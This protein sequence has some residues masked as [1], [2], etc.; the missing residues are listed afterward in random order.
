MQEKLPVEQIKDKRYKTHK[1][2]IRKRKGEM[3]KG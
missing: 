1:N 2:A 3:A